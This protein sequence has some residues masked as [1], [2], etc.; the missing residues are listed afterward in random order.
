M[1]V[2]IGMLGQETNA[3][4][5][6]HCDFQHFAPNGLVEAKDFIEVNKGGNDYP[7][8]MI[9]AAAEEGVDLIPMVGNLTAGAILTAECL[10]QI[11]DILLSFVE[12]H[13]KEIDGIC[14]ALHG[15]GRAETTQDL[16]AY[17]LTKIRE[18]TGSDL[19][20]TVT[21]DLH[22]NITPDMIRLS[23]GL[24]GIKEYPHVDKAA[25]GFLA[26][27]A[28]IRIIR[29]RQGGPAYDMETAFT[30]LPL[31][32]PPL[33][34]STFEWPME[35]VKDYVLACKEKYGLLDASFFHG[36]PYTDVKDAV[37]SVLAI[38]PRGKDQAKKAVR[39][40]AGYV[41][42]RRRDFLSRA[43]S[44]REAIDRALAVKTDGYVVI[45]ESSDNPGGG[46]PGDGTYLLQA[47]L[48]RNAGP[49]IFCSI[50]DPEMVSLAVEA[51]VGG[52]VSGFLGGKTDKFHGRPIP[53]KDAF[54]CCLSEGVYICN[55][56][57]QA[58]M[59]IS[60]GK[61]ARLRLGQVEMVVTSIMARQTYCDGPFI[62]AGADLNHYRLI[63]IKSSNHFKAF[64]KKRAAAIITAD[65]P[66]IQTSQFDTLPF[67]HLPCNVWPL[68]SQAAYSGEVQIF[69]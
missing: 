30:Q 12:K 46:T 31:L 64:F 15:A 22:A 28:L 14:L 29:S 17:T 20:I 44:P 32:I 61:T 58:G 5:A 24:F 63:A 53:I 49:T 38:G 9:R 54:V 19:P 27:K 69:F 51:G 26:M 57:V 7:G 11:T 55:S 3:F 60:M 56:P 52:K 41:W 66:G 16:E 65:P 1:K 25:A 18:V 48:E 59:V 2:L 39:D 45:N 35:E 8:G 47:M 62:A 37:A 23:Q 40:I 33:I 50:Y 34:G 36:F 6:E 42:A 10:E 43:L 67:E 4:A 21:L 68:S 13:G